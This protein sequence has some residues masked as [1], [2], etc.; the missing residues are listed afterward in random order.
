M[1]KFANKKLSSGAYVPSFAR[2]LSLFSSRARIFAARMSRNLF[3]TTTKTLVSGPSAGV[4]FI[5]G[6][7]VHLVRCVLLRPKTVDSKQHE[8]KGQLSSLEYVMDIVD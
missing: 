7:C 5:G 6:A 4:Q 8:G 2:S 3:I 1:L